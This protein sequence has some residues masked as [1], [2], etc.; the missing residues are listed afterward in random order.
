MQSKTFISTG[1][2]VFQCFPKT[3]FSINYEYI[4]GQNEKNHEIADTW[5]NI[6]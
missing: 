5:L 3:A 4:T 2:N 6:A 1:Q